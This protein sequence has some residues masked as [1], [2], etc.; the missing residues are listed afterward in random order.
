MEN[1][2]YKNKVYKIVYVIISCSFYAEKNYTLNSLFIVL[3][4]GGEIRGSFKTFRG[5]K[6]VF[7]LNNFVIKLPQRMPWGN[8]NL[9]L[10]LLPR[11]CNK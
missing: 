1:K 5:K 10:F 6:I 7:I 4:P 8:L 2:V 9:I 3:R 11:Q